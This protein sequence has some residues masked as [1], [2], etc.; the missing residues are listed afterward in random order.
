MVYSNLEIETF[1]QQLVDQAKKQLIYG[2]SEAVP[3]ACGQFCSPSCGP[4]CSAGKMIHIPV[5]SL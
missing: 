4:S 1:Q 5:K 2:G 3:F